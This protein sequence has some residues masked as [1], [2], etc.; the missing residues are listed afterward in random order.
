LASVVAGVLL[1]ALPAY[2]KGPSDGDVHGPPLGTALTV[3]YFVVVPI[4]ILAVIAGLTMVPTLLRRRQGL[5]LPEEQRALWFA[6]P[7][8]ASSTL[9]AADPGNT[10][11]GGASADW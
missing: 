11:R 3:V 7:P 1:V 6:G 10:A 2:A 8:D 5:A 4:A 9:S